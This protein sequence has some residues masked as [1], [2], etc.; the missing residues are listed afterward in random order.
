[1]Q[2]TGILKGIDDLI[3]FVSDILD[4]Y[5]RRGRIT[6]EIRSA[7]EDIT[8]EL[9]KIL[10][11]VSEDISEL[12]EALFKPHL[13]SVTHFVHSLYN[14]ESKGWPTTA[15]KTLSALKRFKLVVRTGKPLIP[16][17]KTQAFGLPLS[18]PSPRQYLSSIPAAA[19]RIA[20]FKENPTAYFYYAKLIELGE[21]ATAEQ[22]SKELNVSEPQVRMVM[23]KLINAGLVNVRQEKGGKTK[24]YGIKKKLDIEAEF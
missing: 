23:K 3:F 17:E 5:Y 18:S 14:F 2:Q 15:A 24:Y 4:T 11:Q 13:D 8:E 1:M 16:E 12:E 7:V 10:D 21:T 9:G 20:V 6:G 19:L 22:M